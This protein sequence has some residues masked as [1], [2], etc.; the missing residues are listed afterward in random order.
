MQWPNGD[1]IFA[2]GLELEC[3]KKALERKVSRGILGV[4]AKT[5]VM[6]N[7]TLKRRSKP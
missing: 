4:D 2:C 1:R 5:V 6:W 7:F 3:W